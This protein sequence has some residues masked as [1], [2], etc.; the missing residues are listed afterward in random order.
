MERFFD[1]VGLILKSIGVAFRVKGPVSMVVSVVGFGMAF[2]PLLISLQ[3]QKLTDEITE[4]FGTSAL[5]IS[6][7]LLTFFVLAAFYLVRT[8]FGFIQDY[9]IGVDSVKV[10]KHLRKHLMEI[11][12]DVCYK[13]VENYDGFKDKIDFIDSVSGER[14]ASSIQSLVL[15]LQYLVLCVSLIVLLGGVNAWIVVLVLL[16]SIPTLIATYKFNTDELMTKTFWM[17]EA[18]WWH[19]YGHVVA[20]PSYK[21]ELRFFGLYEYMVDKLA[22][23][24]NNYLSIKKKRR[25]VFFAVNSLSDLLRN[26]IMIAVLLLTA[27]QIYN[28]PTLGLGVFMLVFV[29]TGQ[30]QD[31][32]SQFFIKIA[33]FGGNIDYM[34]DYF[35]LDQLERE[36]PCEEGTP[37]PTMDIEVENLSFTYPNATFKAIDGLSVS[38][39]PGE[40]IAIVGENGSGKTTFVNLLCGMYVPDAGSIR[41]NGRPLSQKL[42][43]VRRSI[44]AVF[45]DFCCYEAT[46]RE[47]IAVSDESR[48]ADDNEI[49]SLARPLGALEFIEKQ[50]SGLDE[51]IGLFSDSGNNLSG[52]QWQKIAILRAAYRHDVCMMVLDEPTAA[53]DP[54]SE[55]MLYK[56]FAGLTGNKTTLLIS[57]RLGITSVVDRILVFDKGRIVEDGPHEELMKRNGRYAEMYRAQAQW[58]VNS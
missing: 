48:T 13:Y 30:L 31:A 56:E 43:S 15:C 55:A 24:H 27:H 54:I 32:L 51:M 6:R 53:L 9:T 22:K 16:T 5:D 57:H 18:H 10:Q 50:P 38:I 12:C 34:R 8:L 21:P 14:V 1:K 44:S 40:K 23:Y 3:L 17:K 45:Q 39:R 19:H 58:Y 26:G 25:K 52:G 35:S 28:K 36:P 33:Q 2:F 47:N 7:V 11:T 20:H 42:A 46:L 4:L 29:S 41:V 37:L 49:L